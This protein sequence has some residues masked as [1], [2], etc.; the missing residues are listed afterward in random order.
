MPAK[1]KNVSTFCGVWRHV[2]H[3]QRLWFTAFADDFVQNCGAGTQNGP[4]HF[5]LVLEM[6]QDALVVNLYA[7][8][9]RVRPT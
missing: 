8:A 7:V 6:L 1:D 5:P 2:L 4:S 3:V 9:C